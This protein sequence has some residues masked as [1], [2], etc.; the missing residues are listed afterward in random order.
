MR[1]G[2]YELPIFTRIYDHEGNVTLTNIDRMEPVF[3]TPFSRRNLQKLLDSGDV[4]TET[5]FVLDTGTVRYGDFTAYEFL[6]KSFDDLHEKAL[7]G[8]YPLT[9]TALPDDD[10]STGRWQSSR[11]T[12]ITGMPVRTDQNRLWKDEREC[13]DGGKRNNNSKR[14]SSKKKIAMNDPARTL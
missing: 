9:P 10:K 5:K 11:N 8:R 7:T 2:Y 12:E 6:N 4:E 14:S 3:T 1:E 13:S